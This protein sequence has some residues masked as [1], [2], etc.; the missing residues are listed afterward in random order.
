MQQPA[1][2]KRGSR[3]ADRR[4]SSISHRSRIPQSHRRRQT[5]LKASRP[6]AAAGRE[7]AAVPFGLVEWK[8]DVDVDLVVP[9]R[10]RV[11]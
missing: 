7:E 5:T 3:F 2:Q 8:P 6:A 9:T 4:V 11:C 10:V 1:V